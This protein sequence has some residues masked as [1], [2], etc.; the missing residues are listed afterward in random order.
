M[1]ELEERMK[2]LTPKELHNR[3]HHLQVTK[4]QTKALIKEEKSE[5]AILLKDDLTR[6]ENKQKT[7]VTKCVVTTVVVKAMKGAQTPNKY[8]L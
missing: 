5:V 4:P 8:A 3:L 1:E 7:K 2:S 6:R